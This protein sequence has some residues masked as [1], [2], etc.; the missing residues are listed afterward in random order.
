[1]LYLIQRYGN[2]ASLVSQN[3]LSETR[4]YYETYDCPSLA[5]KRP[6]LVYHTID[7]LDNHVLKCLFPFMSVRTKE[8]WTGAY[9]KGCLAGSR[10]QDYLDSETCYRNDVIVSL[11]FG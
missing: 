1:M 10:V 6:N 5:I 8:G 4:R 3:R 7:F 9:F 11:R 2:R